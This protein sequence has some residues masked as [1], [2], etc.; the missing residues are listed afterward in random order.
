MKNLSLITLL[1]IVLMIE[2][3]CYAISGRVIDNNTGLPIRGALIVAHWTEE[4]GLPGLTYHKPYK[5]L[6]SE[7]NEDGKFSFEKVCV[8]FESVEKP[9]VLIYKEGYFPWRNDSDLILKF[10][11]DGFFV[12]KEYESVGS[13][14]EY[15]LNVDD[16]TINPDELY[17]FVGSGFIG[18]NRTSAPKASALNSKLG[19]RVMTKPLKILKGGVGGGGGNAERIEK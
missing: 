7:S 8:M 18:V 11:K 1:S 17:Y 19:Q 6:E 13:Y 14:R 16:N 15:R 9:A 12:R 4:C 5:I 10:D 3:C 2:G